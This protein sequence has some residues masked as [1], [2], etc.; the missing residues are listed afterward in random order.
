MLN[1][2]TIVRD[3]NNWGLG[4]GM[5]QMPVW[6]NLDF[7]QPALLRSPQGR[8]CLFAEHLTMQVLPSLHQA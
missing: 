4:R 2:Q 3:L 5:G 8:A 1:A 6:R 7:R